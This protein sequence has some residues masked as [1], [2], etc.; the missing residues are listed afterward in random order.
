MAKIIEQKSATSWEVI[1]DIGPITTSYMVYD[2]DPSIDK[3]VHDFSR[4]S[5]SD[6]DSIKE[7]LGVRNGSQGDKG[8][9]QYTYDGGASL[10]NTGGF[11]YQYS[12]DYYSIVISPTDND[13]NSLVNYFTSILG[14]VS[15]KVYIT[16]NTNGVAAVDVWNIDSINVYQIDY[17]S[18]GGSLIG[19]SP[20]LTIGDSYSINIVFAGL[21]G[22]GGASGSSGT[23]GSSGSSGSSGITGGHVLTKPVT[24][25]TYSARLNGTP[26]FTYTTPGRDGMSLYP[27]IPANSLTIKNLKINVASVVAGALVRIL[28]YSDLNGVPSSKLLEST[29]LDASTQG[30]KTYTASFTFTAGTTYWLGVHSSSTASLIVLDAV[31]MMS[32]GGSLYQN[33]T[34]VTTTITFPNAPATLSTTTPSTGYAFSIILTAA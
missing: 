5:Q 17:F 20:T 4:L 1:E 2:D 32:I 11:S 33:N 6:M 15:A 9:L 7:S 27:F 31:A 30:D 10:P 26:G 21:E 34:N 14:S 25:R 23:S 12:D 8:G 16:S 29:S 22:R 28:V 13:R 3:Y 19:S 18:L 24:D